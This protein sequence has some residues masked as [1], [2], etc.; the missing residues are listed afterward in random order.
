MARENAVRR[1]KVKIND[2]VLKSKLRRLAVRK[3]GQPDLWFSP[4]RLNLSSSGAEGTRSCGPRSG[5]ETR[6]SCRSCGSS[7]CGRR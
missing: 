1:F 2:E 7:R 3:S 5:S 6:C 4:R